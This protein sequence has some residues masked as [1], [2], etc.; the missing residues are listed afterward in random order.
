[1]TVRELQEL[2]IPTL[3]DQLFEVDV[4]LQGNL[5]GEAREAL[6]EA[7]S[8]LAQVK[9]K[10]N[11]LGDVDPMTFGPKETT[12]QSLLDKLTYWK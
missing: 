5:I 4:A 1:M 8:T 10:I 3:E 9:E 7:V 12:E 11:A 6:F 2:V